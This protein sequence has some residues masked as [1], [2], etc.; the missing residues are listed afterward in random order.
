MFMV[1]EGPD[2]CTNEA[3]ARRY[4]AELSGWGGTCDACTSLSDDHFRGLHA[5]PVADCHD[6]F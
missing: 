1:L 6:C 4:N 2:I 3:C 5:E